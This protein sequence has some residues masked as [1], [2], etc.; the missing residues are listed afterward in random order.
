MS[1]Q[2]VRRDGRGLRGSAPQR[3]QAPPLLA[4]AMRSS[5][6]GTIRGCCAC[7]AVTQGAT[8]RSAGAHLLLGGGALI[9]G[10]CSGTVLSCAP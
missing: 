1:T 7:T 3:L 2:A 10:N 4:P 8:K 5:A 9:I 6:Q